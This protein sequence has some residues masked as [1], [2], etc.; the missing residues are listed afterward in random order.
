LSLSKATCPNCAGVLPG[1]PPSR[2]G[3]TIY[4]CAPRAGGQTTRLL[5]LGGFML[6][7]RGHVV[8]LQPAAQRVIAYT[9][10]RQ[11]PVARSV[12][13]GTIWPD[14][15]ESRA[16]AN[17]RSTLWRLRGIGGGS[18]RRRRWTPGPGRG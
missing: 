2:S 1:A 14:V 10:L 18:L 9:A 13:A 17:L 16:A 15:T 8:D 3:Q 11:G 7:S 12:I 6:V 5:L 4:D